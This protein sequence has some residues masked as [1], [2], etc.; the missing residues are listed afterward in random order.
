MLRLIGTT[1]HSDSRNLVCH[2]LVSRSH[3]RHPNHPHT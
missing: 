2:T 1:K 3:H